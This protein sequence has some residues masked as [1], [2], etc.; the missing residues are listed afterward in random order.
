MI[1]KQHSIA[2]LILNITSGI[3]LLANSVNYKPT[4]PVRNEDITVILDFNGVLVKNGGETK[5]VGIGKFIP[6]ALMHGFSCK[7]RLKNNMFDFFESIECRTPDQAHACDQDGQVLPQLMC[8]WMRGNQTSATILQKI[9]KEAQKRAQGLEIDLITSISRMMFTPELFAQTQHLVYDAVQFVIELKKQGY[10][11]IVCT[12][13][14]DETF[15]IIEQKLAKFFALVDG[16]VVSGRVGLL[17]PEP[18]IYTYLLNTYSID[19]SKAFF[20]DDQLVNVEGARSVGITSVVCPAK[21]G[22]FSSASDAYNVRS[23]FYAWRS[24]LNTAL[25][26]A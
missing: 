16:I 18:A 3:L 7:K 20:I 6:Y 17:K 14:D 11:V 15:A 4:A 22:V 12:N 2:L 13:F 26:T 8:E 9:E 21:K 19:P 25:A 5:I 23:Q 10:K 1:T 24:R